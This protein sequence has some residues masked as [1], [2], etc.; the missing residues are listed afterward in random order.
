MKE[1]STTS[2]PCI[3]DWKEEIYRSIKNIYMSKITSKSQ[4]MTFT[5]EDAPT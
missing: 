4:Q 2:L 3:D 1:R 5:T